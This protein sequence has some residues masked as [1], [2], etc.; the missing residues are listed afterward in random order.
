VRAVVLG[1]YAVTVLDD[2]SLT[3]NAVE[4]DDG[5]VFLELTFSESYLAFEVQTAGIKSVQF[6]HSVSLDPVSASKRV[7]LSGSVFGTHQLLLDCQGQ[8]T[9]N[10]LDKFIGSLSLVSGDGRLVKRDVTIDHEYVPSEF[11]SNAAALGAAIADRAQ[12]LD[13]TI[14]YEDSM[15]P[16]ESILE[17]EVSEEV[18]YS[19]NRLVV[20]PIPG[21][22]SVVQ[23]TGVEP[24]SRRVSGSVLALTYAVAEAYAIGKRSLL[25]GY[26]SP[27]VNAP[28][29][30]KLTTGFEFRP[31]TVGIADGVRETSTTNVRAV[32]VRFDFSEILADY[33]VP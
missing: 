26:G 1:N 17:C 22:Y 19:G 23:N 29:P 4:A 2:S 8:V 24:G 6:G 10:F 16:A 12:K 14:E 20:H 30:E 21:G 31:L 11:T 28:R 25:T 33:P 3:E 13:F 5:S 15:T 7:R 18:Q 9:G 27:V 32:R